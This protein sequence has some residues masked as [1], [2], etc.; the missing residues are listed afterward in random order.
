MKL[1]RT[2]L[3]DI[4]ARSMRKRIWFRELTAIERSLVNLT[5]R[6]VDEVKSSRLSRLLGLIVQ[7]LEEALESK[8]L[9]RAWEMGRE[10]ARRFARIAYSWGNV[11]ALSWVRDSA[12][13]LYLGVSSM[14]APSFCV[15]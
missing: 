13:I 5:I 14:N 3:V 9:R 11:K 4:R 7:R 10:L 6:V 2:V 12:Y 1:T 8:F 15:L